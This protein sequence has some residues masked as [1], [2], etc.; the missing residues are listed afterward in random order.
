MFFLQIVNVTRLLLQIQMIL[1]NVSYLSVFFNLF[2]NYYF[3]KV[4]HTPEKYTIKKVYT[5]MRK[6]NNIIS[7]VKHKVS[8]YAPNIYIE[9]S[10][11]VIWKP[12]KR[13]KKCK[14]AALINWVINSQRTHINVVIALIRTSKKKWKDFHLL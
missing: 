13:M 2:D 14:L 9:I 6:T 5:T 11:I 1:L 4:C 7:F 10:Y 8:I 12:I 3:R